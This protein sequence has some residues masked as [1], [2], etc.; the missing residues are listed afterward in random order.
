MRLKNAI[1]ST[2][3]VAGLTAVPALATA[4]QGSTQTAATKACTL[5]VTGM[6]CGGC[7]SAVKK[8]ATKV[9]GVTDATVSYEKG[10]AV[11]TYDPA[12]TTPDAIAKA[13]TEKAGFR[14]EVVTPPANKR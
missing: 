9:Q 2:V 13:V 6:T 1:V 7:A 10:E 4:R 12:R 8:A 3:L 5:K 11:V 14:A